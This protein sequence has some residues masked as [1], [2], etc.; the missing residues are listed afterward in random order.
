MH[1]KKEE[2][3]SALSRYLTAAGLGGTVAG[4]VTRSPKQALANAALSGGATMLGDAMM[5]EPDTLL[6]AAGRGAAGGAL[7]GMPMGFSAM[8]TKPGGSAL[9]RFLMKQGMSKKA[10]LATVL[11]GATVGGGLGGALSGASDATTAKALIDPD[12]NFY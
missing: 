5:G 1:A 2:K 10:A 3:S 4:L 9:I 12:T 8:G 11:G 6:G 7:I